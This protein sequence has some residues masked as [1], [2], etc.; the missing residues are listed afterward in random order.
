MLLQ[1]LAAMTTFYKDH[2]G[3]FSNDSSPS[4]IFFDNVIESVSGRIA[5][6]SSGF[7]VLM[8]ILSDATPRW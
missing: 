4:R 5:H 1:T 6:I 8:V 3:I 7:L 2:P